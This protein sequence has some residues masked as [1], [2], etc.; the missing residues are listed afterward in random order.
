MPVM[1]DSRT[2]AANTT[3]ENIL[4]GKLHEFISG[5]GAAAIRV[6]ISAAAAGVNASCLVGGESFAQDQAVSNSNRFPQ[7][8]ED[9]FVQMGGIQGDRITVGLRN[10]TGAGIVV[11]TRVEVTAAG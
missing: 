1:T 10:T 9:F 8:P 11:Q 4:A 3:V 2:V 6:F 7:D 5:M